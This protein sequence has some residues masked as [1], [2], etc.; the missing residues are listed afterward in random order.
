MCIRDSNYSGYD[1]GYV[2]I[3]YS[4]KRLGKARI[5]RAYQ[6]LAASEF[7]LDSFK[8]NY[9]GVHSHAYAQD[10]SLIHI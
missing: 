2:G 4:P 8:N 6:R 9:I 3:N 5:Y 10:L 1:G 7:I